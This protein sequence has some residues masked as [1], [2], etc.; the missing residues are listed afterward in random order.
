MNIVIVGAGGIGTHVAINLAHLKRANEKVFYRYNIDS[1][2]VVD[3]DVV[4]MKNLNR[5][6][7]KKYVGMHKVEALQNYIKENIMD[8]ELLRYGNL[9]QE[10][11]NEI[12]ELLDDANEVALVIDC[13]DNSQAQTA[14]YNFC[15][16]KHH[17]GYVHVGN[18]NENITIEINRSMHVCDFG[19]APEGYISTQTNAFYVAR[20][21]GVLFDL[22][23]E[24]DPMQ[25]VEVLFSMTQKGIWM[26]EDGKQIPMEKIQPWNNYKRREVSELPN[27]ISAER[28]SAEEESDSSDSN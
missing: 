5:L 26:T 3:A 17:F 16:V 2:I 11:E 15:R 9:W 13:T 28:S 19:T 25:G 1:I 24:Y 21:M 22:L 6:P 7:Y 27:D 4:E 8:L 14:I 10:V 12:E 18:Q 20:T 23:C